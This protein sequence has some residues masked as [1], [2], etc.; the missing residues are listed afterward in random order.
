MA[1]LDGLRNDLDMSNQAEELLT[2]STD[3]HSKII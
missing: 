1:H 3:R 2:G